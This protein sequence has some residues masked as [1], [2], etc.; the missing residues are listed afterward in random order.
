MI[1]FK[2]QREGI[3]QYVLAKLV[4]E[5]SDDSNRGAIQSLPG[6]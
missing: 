2:R 6:Q 1:E 3:L 4:L 5:K